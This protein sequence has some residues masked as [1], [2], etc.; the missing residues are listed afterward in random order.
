MANRLEEPVSTTIL[1]EVHSRSRETS[2][3][4]TPKALG[5]VG[6][7]PPGSPCKGRRLARPWSP[8]LADHQVEAIDRWG[9]AEVT[10]SAGQTR[11]MGQ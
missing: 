6:P 8:V 9:Y 7:L 4:R 2:S 11:G 3:A 1:V 5:A 10:P